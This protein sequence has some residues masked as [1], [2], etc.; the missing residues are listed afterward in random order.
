MGLAASH[1][2]HRRLG[3]RHD[4]SIDRV[5]VGKDPYGIEFGAQA[6]L[7]AKPGQIVHAVVQPARRRV[8]GD[9]FI[10][11]RAQTIQ[12]HRG[13][14]FNGFRQGNQARPGARKT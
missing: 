11:A 5:G 14:A 1:D 9:R 4:Q 3:C 10:E 6:R 13:G 7:Y 8:E 12:V 2:A